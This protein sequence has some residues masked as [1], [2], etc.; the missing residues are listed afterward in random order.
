MIVQF[1]YL[2]ESVYKEIN[3]SVAQYAFIQRTID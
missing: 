1:V 2:I 3:N